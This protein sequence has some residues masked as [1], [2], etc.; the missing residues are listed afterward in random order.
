M[1]DVRSCE[2]CGTL[3]EPRREHARFCS[4]ECRTAW[5]RDKLGDAAPESSAL[6]WS[7]SAMDDTAELLAGVG[8]HDRPK[9]VAV[10]GDMVW[11]VTIVD[12]TLVRHHPDPYDRILDDFSFWRRRRVEGI[13]GGL[14]FVRNRMRKEAGCG[15][16]IGPSPDGQR[17][18]WMPV[19]EPSL[20]GLGERSAEWELT[21]YRSYQDFLA[22][23]TTGE[24]FDQAIAFLKLAAES[25]EIASLRG[26]YW[27]VASGLPASRFLEAAH[28]QVMSFGG[29]STTVSNRSGTLRD[30][31]E[32]SGLSSCR[33]HSHCTIGGRVLHAAKSAAVTACGLDHLVPLV[34]VAGI[35]SGRVADPLHVN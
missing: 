25:A 13:L 7:V 9:A 20:E 26:C 32:L 10:I 17:W 15:T 34:H 3:F 24:V 21:R 23:Y 19:P 33:D 14:R 22:G 4:A 35:R 18:W 11:W 31:A 27:G 30:C 28:G 5:N 1:G 6:H 8:I 16:F 29:H 2:Q 12:A